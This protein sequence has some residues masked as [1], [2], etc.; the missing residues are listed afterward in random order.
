[1]MAN[2][3]ERD[4]RALTLLGVAAILMLG[5]RLW[6]GR[7]ESGAASA[8][9]A[10]VDM[11]PL[12]EARLGRARQKLATLPTRQA[13]LQQARQEL[14]AREKG[15][16]QADT[17]AQAQAQIVQVLRRVART[18]QPP[19]DIRGVEIGSVSP[20]DDHYG[21]VGVTVTLDAPVEYLVNFL[22]D[23]TAVPEAVATSDLR[24]TPGNPKEKNLPT[25]LTVVG[26]VPARLI[27]KKDRRT[28]QG[29][30][31]F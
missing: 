7:A 31:A 30:A 1:M 18:Q 5:Y 28:A 29:G 11:I 4:R 19:L 13:Q 20:V 27:P 3:S 26:L 2:L 8:P 14:A 6:T 10:T 24:I 17:A 25:R 15:L 21:A 9:K 23:L 22:A 16:L 12:L